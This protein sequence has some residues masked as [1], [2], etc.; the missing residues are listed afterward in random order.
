MPERSEVE[1]SDSC[2][3]RYSVRGKEDGAAG[4]P[5]GS[6]CASEEGGWQRRR[7]KDGGVGARVERDGRNRSGGEWSGDE[8]WRD[9]FHEV[10]LERQ[11]SLNRER[12]AKVKSK[13]HRFVLC[14]GQ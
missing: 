7:L 13:S 6:R 12:D 2:L 4:G 9:G 8:G 10:L 5:D 3:Q 1:V 14:S 11:L